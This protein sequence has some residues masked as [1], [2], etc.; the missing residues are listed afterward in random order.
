LSRSVDF[1]VIGVASWRK[2]RV[3]HSSIDLVLLDKPFVLKRCGLKALS[4]LI[5]LELSR[6]S[7]VPDPARGSS[8]GREIRTSVSSN[9]MMLQ[10]ERTFDTSR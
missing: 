2:L 5:T 6:G 10:F 1:G 7:I 3:M 8:G 9:V 4:E